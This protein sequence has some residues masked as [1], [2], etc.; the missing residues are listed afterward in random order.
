MSTFILNITTI[1]NQRCV[2]CLDGDLTKKGEVLDLSFDDTAAQIDEA[3]RRGFENVLFMGGETNIRKD[4]PR[5]IEYVRSLEMMPWVATNGTRFDNMDFLRDLVVARGLHGIEMSYH[6]HVEET[7]NRLSGVKVTWRRQ[8]KALR[9]LLAL[10]NEV[11]G[12]ERDFELIFN[13]VITSWN[14]EELDGLVRHAVEIFGDEFFP[15]FK[16]KALRPKARALEN[17]FII[18]RHSAVSPHL[19]RAL[20]YA[21]GRGIECFVETVPICFLP[22]HEHRALE[23]TNIVQ[24]YVYGGWNFHTGLHT[25]LCRNDGYGGSYV[26]TP[27]CEGCTLDAICA[28]PWKEYVEVFD[29]SE[30]HASDRDA[31]A[32][33]R[34]VKTGSD[35]NGRDDRGDDRDNARRDEPERDS[36]PPPPHW[37]NPVELFRRGARAVAGRL[38]L[39]SDLRD[40]LSPPRSTP[41]D[42]K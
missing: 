29:T 40:W 1:C 42:R 20:D 19:V 8:E 36:G 13:T 31:V 21:A 32:I 28:G 25:G 39:S 26:K 16:F 7:A 9:N 34:R 2:F 22:G 30:F 11:R 23:T 5:I 35:G 41:D 24:D 6:S 15:R 38:P 4:F 10:K 27:G 14:F 12:S 17:R 18:P 33:A 37:Y 3:K